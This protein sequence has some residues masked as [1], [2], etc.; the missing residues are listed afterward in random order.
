M[1]TTQVEFNSYVKN[2]TI[3]VPENL[4]SAVPGAVYVIVKPIYEPKN[5]KEQPIWLSGNSKIDN[6]AHIGEKFR[7]IP[8]DELYER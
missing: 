8:R 1:Q 7:K 2:G 5:V 4:I 3:A 6:P